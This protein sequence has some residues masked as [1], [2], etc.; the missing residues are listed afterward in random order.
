VL[1]IPNMTERNDKCP[2]GSGKKYKK[3]CMKNFSKGGSPLMKR[4][5]I[6]SEG[7]GSSK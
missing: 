3:C 1:V 5:N 7:V 2:C 6:D 4:L